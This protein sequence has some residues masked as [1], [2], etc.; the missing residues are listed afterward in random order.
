MREA[1]RPLLEHRRAE[2]GEDRYLQWD[3]TPETTRD[4]F[5]AQF[6]AGYGP[7]NPDKVP[8]YLLLVGNPKS[9][10]FDF[11]YALD[12]QYAVGRLH[13]ETAEEYGHYA[14]GVLAAETGGFRRPK[15]MTFFA[16]EHLGDEGSRRMCR[17]LAEPLARTLAEKSSWTQAS[18]LADQASKD[19]LSR[20][21]GKEKTPALLFTATHGLGYSY[22]NERLRANQ[23]ALICQDWGGPGSGPLSP[24]SYFSAADVGDD[25]DLRGLLAFHLA[26]YSGGTPEISYYRDQPGGGPRRVADFPFISRLAQRLLGHPNGGALAVLGHIDRAWTTSFDMLRRRIGEIEV[27]E[28]TLS[29]LLDGHRAGFAMEYLNQRFAELSVALSDELSG[30]EPDKGRAERLFL[31]SHDAR[32]FVLLGD[33]AVRLSVTG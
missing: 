31:A 1:L 27:Y 32:A 33:P 10:L 25:A 13:F 20:L 16:A 15:K 4:S 30:R 21:M 11:Q 29:P 26:C 18:F 24:D 6:G 5:L 22:P 3:F 12:L 17:K 23:G 7:P 19:L 8:Y 14:R 28:S 9:L 2:A